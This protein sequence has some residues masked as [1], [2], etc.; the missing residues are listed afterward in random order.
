MFDTTDPAIKYLCEPLD[1]GNYKVYNLV[2]TKLISKDA[3]LK[4]LPDCLG[5]VYVYNEEY[6]VYNDLLYQTFNHF[7]PQK[8]IV[9][10]VYNV[11]HYEIH[12]GGMQNK[13]YWDTKTHKRVY[14]KNKHTIKVKSGTFT[15]D[16]VENLKYDEFYLIVPA[17]ENADNIIKK[18]ADKGYEVEDAF[19][20]S[21]KYGFMYTY[22]LK[23]LK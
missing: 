4:W 2:R 20:S 21:S 23:K 11:Y 8:D 15:D 14:K 5:D 13:I 7:N 3:Q 17:R 12:A 9:M 10:K 6:S 19:R 1:T 18:L 16:K 22:K